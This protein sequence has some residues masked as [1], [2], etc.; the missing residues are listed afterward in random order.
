MLKLDHLVVTAPR[1][2]DG[3][4]VVER[5]L[6]VPLAPGGRH[7]AMATENRLLR[8]GDGLYLE[9]I[10]PDPDAPPPDRPRWFAMD[11]PM[12]HVRLSNWVLRTDDLD[13]ALAGVPLALG[14]P[15]DFSRGAFRW[16]MAVPQDGCLPFEGAVPALIEWQGAQHPAD[17]L[18]DAGCRLRDLTISHP[19]IDSLC[20]AF[21]ALAGLPKVRLEP[22]PL[23][24]AA[25]I[26]TPTGTWTLA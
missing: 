22:G 19:A 20:R 5:A 17:S 4:D 12:P 13:A 18:P 3:T 1:L 26:D 2:S 15:M 14:A 11:R 8:L 10:A 25:R 21:P 16:R 9:V 23:E 7:A 24:L 6:G